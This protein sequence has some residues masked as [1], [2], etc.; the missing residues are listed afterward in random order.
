MKS[1]FAIFAMLFFLPILGTLS[2]QARMDE[3]VKADMPFDFYAGTQKMPAGLYYL[4]FDYGSDVVE[5]TNNS[6]N[7]VLLMGVEANDVTFQ[8]TQLVFDRLGE[9]YF[10]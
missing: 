9:N 4:R 5:L 1:K 7:S 3:A 10:L 8:P 6:G 2:A